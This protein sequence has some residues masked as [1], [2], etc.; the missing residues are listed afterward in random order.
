[1]GPDDDSDA[2]AGVNGAAEEVLSCLPEISAKNVED[3]MGKVGSFREFMQ[4]GD[5]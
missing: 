4:R 3:V 2:G 5:R 1:M